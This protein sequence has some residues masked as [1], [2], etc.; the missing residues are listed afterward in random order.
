V[1]I[2]GDYHT[3]LNSMGVTTADFDYDFTNSNGPG[4]VRVTMTPGGGTQ[5]MYAYA[6]TINTD[7]ALDEWLAPPTPPGGG[8]GGG[9]G[10]PMV[11]RAGATPD[12]DTPRN[13]PA[14]VFFATQNLNPVANVDQAS[15][16]LWA[17][18]AL[19]ALY[20]GFASRV[21][22]TVWSG[23]SAAWAWAT[24]PWPTA[25]AACAAIL[26]GPTAA[27]APAAVI[28]GNFAAVAAAAGTIALTVGVILV[29]KSVWPAK[30][31]F[32]SD[33]NTPVTWSTVFH[34]LGATAVTTAAL[35]ALAG[36]IKGLKGVALNPCC[37]QPV[38][39]IIDGLALVVASVVGITTAS[40]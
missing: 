26:P 8:G 33:W 39:A 17:A 25:L 15:A 22:T 14:G 10:L 40:N 38:C 23:I 34:A 7:D 12:D 24:V 18:V 20:S 16:V 28:F 2:T 36:L 35:G 1:A 11:H 19:G 21:A 31:A 5:W 29:L 6:S 27:T 37:N 4:H 30:E 3:D 9:P 32:I 13:M